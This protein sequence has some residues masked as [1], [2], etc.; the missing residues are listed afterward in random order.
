MSFFLVFVSKKRRN[1]PME[2]GNILA[3]FSPKT[4]L[5][6]ACDVHRQKLCHGL[7]GTRCSAARVILSRCC[8]GWRHFLCF[9]HFHTSEMQRLTWQPFFSTRKNLMQEKNPY[10]THKF[11][12]SSDFW[13]SEFASSGQYQCQC[14]AGSAFLTKPRCNMAVTKS[15]NK[16]QLR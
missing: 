8:A 6:M 3:P 5:L 16:T 10:L 7:C 13:Q 9:S 12:C 14:C 11:T 15:L 1:F 4:N 2:N